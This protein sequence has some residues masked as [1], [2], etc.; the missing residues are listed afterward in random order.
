MIVKGPGSTIAPQHEESVE[1]R[2]SDRMEVGHGE[3]LEPRAGRVALFPP[4][5]CPLARSK[6]VIDISSPPELSA[7][8]SGKGIMPPVPRRMQS[9]HKLRFMSKFRP[10][11]MAYSSS[12]LLSGKNQLARCRLSVWFI[13]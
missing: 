10:Q 12:A 6:R 5:L 2:G 7:G 13:P 11:L 3:Q 8:R 4:E 9:K 1:S